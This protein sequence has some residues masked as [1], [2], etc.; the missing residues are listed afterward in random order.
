VKQQTENKFEIE[1]SLL[2]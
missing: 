1:K 2:Y